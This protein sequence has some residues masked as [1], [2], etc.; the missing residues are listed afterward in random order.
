VNGLSLGQKAQFFAEL[1]G[2]MFL[3]KGSVLLEFSA[4]KAA[5]SP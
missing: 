4:V 3:I 2:F 5:L 1:E